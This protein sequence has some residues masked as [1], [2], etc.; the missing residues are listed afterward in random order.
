MLDFHIV[1]VGVYAIHTGWGSRLQ[2]PQLLVT[3][4]DELFANVRIRK[5]FTVWP[6]TLTARA[7]YSRRARAFQYGL[8]CKVRPLRRAAAPPCRL[9]CVISAEHVL[10]GA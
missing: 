7:D 10:S 1:Q 3:Y 2:H 4:A 5:R 6:L 8:S 9:L